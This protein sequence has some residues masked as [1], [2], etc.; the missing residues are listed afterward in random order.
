[1]EKNPSF[2]NSMK[3]RYCDDIVQTFPKLIKRASDPDDLVTG[4]FTDEWGSRFCEVPGGVGSHPTKPIIYS[5]EDWEVYR[6][7]FIP[8]M[9]EGILQGTGNYI[10]VEN[11]DGEKIEMEEP[12]EIHTY[13]GWKFLNRQVKRGEKSVATIQI[14]KHTVKKPK[15]KDEQEQERMFM[16]NAFF[17]TEVQTK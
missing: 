7:K 5:L 15:E 10:T 11:E 3:K 12:E 13:Q 16:T 6:S 2:C 4:E 8:L 9:E 17:F 14:W 1:M